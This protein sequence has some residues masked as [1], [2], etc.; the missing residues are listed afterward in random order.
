MTSTSSFPHPQEHR[1]Y[2]AV[3]RDVFPLE[4]GAAW[5]VGRPSVADV[6]TVEISEGS[7][8]GRGEATPYPRYG[9]T[10]EEIL[11]ILE[12]L[13]EEVAGGMSRRTLQRLLPP[14]AARNALDCALW[15]LDSKRA[16]SSVWQ[17]A[18]FEMPHR[19]NTAFTLGSA[20]AET[21]ARMALNE[22][23]RPVLKLDLGAPDDLARIQA[24]HAAV[25]SAKLIVDAHEG[26]TL[27]MLGRTLPRLA[28][29][30]VV[31]LIQPLP[32]GADFGL[33]GLKHPV[34]IAADESCNDRE[35]LDA[36]P[37]GY[38]AVVVKLDKAGGLTEALALI[39]AARDR[40][41]RVMVGGPLA[42]SLGIAPAV[43]LAQEADWVALDGPLHLARDRQPGLRFDGSLVYPPNVSL[44]G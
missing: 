7:L 27:D 6:V 26:W 4:K 43:I 28:E 8:R 44:W 18:G 17:M 3:R 22:A 1:P 35:S 20:D 12:R 36:L 10:V 41:L 24:V 9:E 25:P 13:A 2:L 31:L 21:M 34:P 32:A 29:L 11:D 33:Q 14:G 42:S 37:P 23:H 5:S 19:V 40:E 16:S 15:D 30:E 39:E 38:D